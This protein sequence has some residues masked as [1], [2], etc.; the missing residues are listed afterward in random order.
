MGPRKDTLVEIEHELCMVKL[1]TIYWTM[2]TFDAHSVCYVCILANNIL[3]WMIDCLE[4]IYLFFSKIDCE[5]YN[6]IITNT[7]WNTYRQ[8]TYIIHKFIDA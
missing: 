7:L 1:E 5:A 8:H 6:F 2:S 3:V 4:E